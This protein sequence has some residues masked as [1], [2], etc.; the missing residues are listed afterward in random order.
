VQGINELPFPVTVD[1][2]ANAVGHALDQL[3]EAA[4]APKMSRK[5]TQVIN[6][7]SGRGPAQ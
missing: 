4:D 2:K 3:I 5:R 1:A 6:P 7:T